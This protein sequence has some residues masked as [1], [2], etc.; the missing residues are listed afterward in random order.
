MDISIELLQ[1]WNFFKQWYWVPLTCIYLAVIFTILIENRNPTK[2]VAWILV[3][4]MIPIVGIIIYYFFGQDFKKDQYFK[5]ND[6]KTSADFIKNWRK[7]NHLIEKDFEVIE[8]RIGAKVKVFKY[9][10]HSLSSP[11]FMNCE[12]KLLQNGEEKFPE[13]I[14]AIRN[15]KHHIHLEYYIFELDDIGNEIINILIEKAND[16]VEVRITTDDFGSPKLNKNYLELFKNTNVQYQTFLPVKFNSLA[17]SNFRNHRKI[18]IIDGEIAFVGG[19]NISD[20]YINNDSN[21]LYWRDTSLLIKGEAVNLLQLKFWMDWKMTDGLDFNIFSYDYIKI[22]D[23]VKNGA[24]VGF[25][26]TTPGAP[27]Q[28]AMESMILAITL[29]KKKVRITTPYFIPSDEFKSALLIAVNSGVEVEL[30]MPKNGDSIIVQEASLSFTKKLMEQNVKVYLYEKG[31]V[32][33]KTIVIDDDLAFIG[34]VNLDNR[35]FFINFELTA[36][37]HDQALITKMIADYEQDKRDSSLMTFAMWKNTS[38]FR[39]AF[40]SVCRLLAPIL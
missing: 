8:E 19:I 35:S 33:A 4:I 16:G 10:N 15:A 12:V 39:R 23:E 27:I 32:H 5:K 7:I 11:P 37:V 28:S 34:T 21:K 24:I 25:A 20:K 2:T 22:H 30:L 6:K 36:I 26:F 1:I 14:H 40:A 13:F 17:N 29:A 18:L 31:F 3:I 38:I 9:L